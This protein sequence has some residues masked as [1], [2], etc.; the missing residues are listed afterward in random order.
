MIKHVV[1]L[2]LTHITTKQIIKDAGLISL[3]VNCDE[4]FINDI[5]YISI[6]QSQTL[7]NLKEYGKYKNVI[8]N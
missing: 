4:L 7:K 1:G 5:D 3:T 6:N 8:N 2:D